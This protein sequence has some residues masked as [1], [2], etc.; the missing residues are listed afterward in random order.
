MLITKKMLA[1]AGAAVLLIGIGIGLLIGRG[2]FKGSATA[3][4]PPAQQA[5]AP[6]PVPSQTQP[7]TASNT[8]PAIKE[9]AK[10][11][12]AQNLDGQDAKKEKD[13]KEKAKEEV[14]RISFEAVPATINGCEWN[15][16]DKALCLVRDG[17]D[18]LVIVRAEYADKK[19]DF[20]P[21]KLTEPNGSACKVDDNIAC[22]GAIHLKEADIPKTLPAALR[23][24]N[25][26]KG[27]LRV[28]VAYD[29][30]PSE[31]A[32]MKETK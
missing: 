19:G 16:H 20:D 11:A 17:K 9:D 21:I 3:A 13:D 22:P 27:A 12:T 18:L 2:Y 25:V 5:A 29:G 24:R 7:T 32:V 23:I 8:Q 28:E 10:P 26:P 6:T 31:I 4:T 30:K 15:M 14:P 1:A